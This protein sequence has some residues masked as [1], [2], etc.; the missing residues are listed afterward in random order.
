M[1]FYI[2]YYHIVWTTKNREPLITPEV[3]Q[4]ICNLVRYRSDT[5]GSPILAINTVADHLHVAVSI[6]P[7]VAVADWV[8][9]VKGVSSREVNLHFPNRLSH[10]R[11]QEGYGAL[12]FGIRQ[13][14]YVVSY[15]ENQKQHHAAS[16]LQPYLEKTDDSVVE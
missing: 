16:T 12:T 13:L 8:K 1:P 10:F 9:R 6:K 5:L 14:D 15:I 7:T 3:E 4:V 11:W 2:C